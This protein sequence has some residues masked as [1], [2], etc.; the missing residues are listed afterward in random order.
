[1]CVEN[2]PN[3]EIDVLVSGCPRT[4]ADSHDGAAS[5]GAASAPASARVLD[6]SDDAPRPIVIPEPDDHLIQH[7]LVQDFD[8]GLFQ[9]VGYF[10][11]LVA[12]AAHQFSQAGTSKRL[13]R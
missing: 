7:Y 2:C 9:L 4:D 10:P 1:M 5:P 13:E 6:R 11:S 3:R 12:V 8:A